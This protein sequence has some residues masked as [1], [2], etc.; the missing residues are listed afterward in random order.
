[1]TPATLPEIKPSMNT[2]VPLRKGD[3]IEYSKGQAYFIKYTTAP[4]SKSLSDIRTHE[5]VIA[6]LSRLDVD[7]KLAQQI[8]KAGRHLHSLLHVERLR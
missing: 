5:A 4:T 7:V 8:R 2:G 1:M 3:R 6:G